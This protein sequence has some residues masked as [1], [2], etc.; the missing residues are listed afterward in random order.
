VTDQPTVLDTA[1]KCELLKE[2]FEGREAVYIEQGFLVVRVSNI[3]CFPESRQAHAIVEEIPTLGL[4]RS[5]FHS[6]NPKMGQPL[7]WKIISGFLTKFSADTWAVGYG[8]WSLFFAP[9]IVA[10]I[11]ALASQFSPEIHA[12]HRYDEAIK[13]LKTNAAYV[14]S[15]RLFS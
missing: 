15:N 14:R 8:S 9:R 1:T 6:R 2:Q 12:V 5:L 4:E 7:R 10:G 3:R 13:F 11:K